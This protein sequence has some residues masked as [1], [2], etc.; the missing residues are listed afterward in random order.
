MTRDI[1]VIWSFAVTF[2]ELRS[3]SF[4]DL[5]SY[6]VC[7]SSLSFDGEAAALTKAL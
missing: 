3:T 1:V 4:V 6:D 7:G 2:E 5:F